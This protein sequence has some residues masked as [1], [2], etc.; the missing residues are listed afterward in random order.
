MNQPPR[1]R[2][3]F[4]RYASNTA[5]M[6]LIPPSFAASAAV[7]ADDSGQLTELSASE[8]VARMSRGE[9]TAERYASALLSRCETLRALNAFITLEPSRVLEAA[10][11]CDKLRSAG[12]KPGPL[13]GLPIPVKDSVNTAEYPTTAGTPGL[14]HFRPAEDAPIVKSL[15]AAGAIVLGKTN[16]HELSYGWTSNNLAFGAVHNPYNPTRI[17]GGSSGGTAV[18]IAAR[19]APLG[20]AEDTE[21]SIRVPAAM[22]GI[23]GFRPTTGRYPT[24]GCAP[25]SPLFDQV[26]PHA[27]NVADLALFDSVAANEWQPLKPPPLQGLRLGIVKEYWFDGLD[28]EVERLTDQALERLRRAGVKIVETQL[29]GLRSLIE[30]STEQIQNHDVRVALARYLED[31][32]TKVTFEQLVAQASTDIQSTFHDYVLPGGKGFVSEKDYA[33]ARDTH[34]PALRQLYRDYFARTGVAAIVFPTTMA[35]ATPIGQDDTVEIRGQKVPFFTVAARNIAPGSTAGLPGLVLPAGLTTTGLPVGI[36]FD[37]P[38]GSDRELLAMGL[39]FE[40]A[41]G[42]IPAPA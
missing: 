32:G 2:R 42:P 39:G 22:C 29:P 18:A 7:R 21:G 13:F 1:S 25:I 9:I 30:Q 41:I 6:T 31:Y 15:R 11:A 37:A 24:K 3:S 19:M 28:P 23:N 20:V 16:L 5:A 8:A 4:I 38:A 27:R 40:R 14:R 10:R 35:A 12:G 36:E 26:G 17:P 33:I 34:L